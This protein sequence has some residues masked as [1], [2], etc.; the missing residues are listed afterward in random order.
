MTKEQLKNGAEEYA[1][2]CFLSFSINNIGLKPNEIENQRNRVMN[3]IKN[4]YLAGYD[5]G[6]VDGQ[7]EPKKRT[8][9]KSG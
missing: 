6:Y 4:A 8:R 2:N 9:K 1:K 5:L 3:Q 7:S